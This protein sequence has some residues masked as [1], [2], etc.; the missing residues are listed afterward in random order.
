MKTVS[1]AEAKARIVT[2]ERI[3]DAP[4]ALLSAAEA[5][6]RDNPEVSAVLLFGSRARGDHRPD[7]DWDL[8]FVTCGERVRRRAPA[9]WRRPD[10]FRV[11][12][13]QV[14]AAVLRLKANAL[15][16]VACPIA[17]EG[18]LLVGAW[19]KPRKLERPAMELEQYE[20]LLQGAFRFVDLAAR[21]AA[22][23]PDALG[24]RQDAA[25]CHNIV[26]WSADAAEYL[27]KAMLG[28]LGVDYLRTH[29]L[30]KLA[31]LFGDAHPGLRDAVRALNGDSRL[32][33]VAGYGAD[34]SGE[35]G[36]RAAARL[37]GVLRLLAEEL[38]A[39]GDDSRFAAYAA[40]TAPGMGRAFAA[41]AAE[42]R[43][44]GGVGAEPPENPLVAAIMAERPGLADALHA[45]GAAISQE[46]A[47]R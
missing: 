23:L 47:S 16:H 5:V 41:R 33:H 3:A 17:R 6:V 29:D 15:R 9:G 25:I 36:R 40:E 31:E 1:A 38:R 30:E 24:E 45:A 34:H 42:L 35:D 22:S 8:A 18:R 4:P 14:P 11:D 37:A 26:S 13:V 28:R 20:T 44:A 27:A 19:Q 2:A 7:S 46:R 10:G 32:D 43:R 21:D 12:C 39:A